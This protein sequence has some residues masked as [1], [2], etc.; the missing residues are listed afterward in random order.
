MDGKRCRCRGPRAGGL[1]RLRQDRAHA[2][3]D[4]AVRERRF[5]AR[6]QEGDGDGVEERSAD[7]QR[8]RRELL[9]VERDTLVRLRD[10]GHIDGDVMRRSERDS[11]SRTTGSIPSPEG[12]LRYG[13]GSAT[14][15]YSAGSSSRVCSRYSRM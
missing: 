12:P 10:D 1:R 15:R 7:Y 9:G 3:G 8:L 2:S 4:P 13:W 14:K 6:L 11:T 5:A